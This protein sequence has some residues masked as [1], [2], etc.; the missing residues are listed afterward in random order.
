MKELSL[1]SIVK[2]QP[3]LNRRAKQAIKLRGKVLESLPQAI[4]M[5]TNLFGSQAYQC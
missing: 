3:W 1:T 5:A 4:V 2:S